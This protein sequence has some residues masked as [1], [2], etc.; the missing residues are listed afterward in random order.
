M[1]WLLKKLFALFSSFGLAVVLIMVL[2]LLTLFGTLEQVDHGLYDV[3]KKYFESLWLVHWLGPVPIPL[4]GG[5]LVLSVFTFNLILG[6]LVRMRKYWKRPGILIVHLG[7]LLMMAAGLVTFKFSK[8]GAMTLFPNE[9]SD[10]VLSYYDWQI[11]IQKPGDKDTLVIAQEDFRDLSSGEERTFYSGT[12]PFDIVLSDYSRNAVP[13]PAGPMIQDRVDAIDGYF[14]RALPKANE[15]ERNIPGAKVTLRDKKSGEEQSALLWGM[16]TEP[17]S[18]KTGDETWTIDLG[19]T[20]WSLPFAI[21]LDEFI[22]ETHPG[23][24][25]DAYFESKIT[26]IDP[27]GD[28]KIRVHMNHPLRHEGTTVFQQGW[29]P[30]NALPGQPLFSTF[31]I[32]RNPAD[33]WP[34]YS[35][36]IISFGLTVHFLQRLTKYVIAENK[37]RLA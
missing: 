35:C 32:V 16:A 33:H 28:E 27:T 3:Q 19:K 15:A 8:G 24:G 37:R 34:L 20:R 18:F 22:R 31:A 9:R 7:M 30:S 17:A 4:P 11:E 25:M 21:Q 13:L 12:L 5:F 6:G 14:L 23:T 2:F 1:T 26:K 10:E 29:G 36:L